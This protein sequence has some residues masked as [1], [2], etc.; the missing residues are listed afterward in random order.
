MG[1]PG[2]FPFY[3]SLFPRAVSNF[4]GTR[5]G[6]K[7]IKDAFYSLYLDSNGPL[8]RAC[9]YVFKYEKDF[10]DRNPEPFDTFK[11]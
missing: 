8:H 5:L 4:R 10:K 2:L 3:K 7:R 6:G 1:V 9:Q 11:Y